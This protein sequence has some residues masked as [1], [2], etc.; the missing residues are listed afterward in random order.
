[1]ALNRALEKCRQLGQLVP[2]ELE[3]QSTWP[4]E[5]DQVG[6]R[7]GCPSSSAWRSA[8]DLSKRMRSATEVASR[9]HVGDHTPLALFVLRERDLGARRLAGRGEG[10]VLGRRGAQFQL[11]RAEPAGWIDALDQDPWSCAVPRSAHCGQSGSRST[12]TG[13]APAKMAADSPCSE[14]A[15]VL[16]SIWNARVAMGTRSGSRRPRQT[17]P[18]PGARLRMIAP[19]EAK[20]LTG[21]PGGGEGQAEV[22]NA[23]LLP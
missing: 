4:R 16:D 14:Q 15:R 10:L 7:A 9:A 5:A 19:D 3:P 13:P 23:S 6:Y 17:A 2:G 21:H 18:A 8:S 11:C 22:M 12:E 20:A 1:M